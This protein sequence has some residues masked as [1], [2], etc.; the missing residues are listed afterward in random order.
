MSLCSFTSV[1]EINKL[2]MADTEGHKHRE[3]NF[4]EGEGN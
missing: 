3:T 4:H 1:L 2:N